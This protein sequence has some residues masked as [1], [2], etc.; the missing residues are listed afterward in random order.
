MHEHCTACVGLLS[1]LPAC[2][3]DTPKLFHNTGD[4][5]ENLHGVPWTDHTYSV[6]SGKACACVLHIEAKVTRHRVSSHRAR[7]RSHCDTGRMVDK[8]RCCPELSMLA[9]TSEGQIETAPV[10]GCTVLLDPCGTQLHHQLVNIMLNRAC[11]CPPPLPQQLAVASVRPHTQPTQHLSPLPPPHPSVLPPGSWGC[12]HAHI[13]PR[14][15]GQ[16]V[17]C[18][19]S[20]II[21]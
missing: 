14:F 6:L 18:A 12:L 8:I 15:L 17:Y 13:K 2:Y 5:C 20:C 3:T 9:T 10:T 21:F 1:S 16:Q 19:E 4:D 7:G 11:T